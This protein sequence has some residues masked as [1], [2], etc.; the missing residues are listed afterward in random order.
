MPRYQTQTTGVLAGLNEDE[1]PHVLKDNELTKAENLARFG[2]D[3]GTRPGLVRPG[4]GE[5]YEN[6][7]SDG[8]PIQ[9]MWEYRQN[10]DE[11]RQ[12]LAV[13][14]SSGGSASAQGGGVFFEDASELDLSSNSVRVTNG[15]DHLWSFAENQNNLFA[16]GGEFTSAA[17]ADDIWHWDGTTGN[18]VDVLALTDSAGARIRPKHIIDFG[19]YLVIN[20]LRGGTIPDNNPAVSR[21][22]TFGA[23]PTSTNSWPNGNTI[24]FNA[25][26]LAGV[27]D[28]GKL[29]TTGFARYE[30]N[31][32]KFLLVLGN[33]AIAAVKL[34]I[35]N[36][37][38]VT[39]GIP[40]GCVHE[41]AFVSLGLDAG[42]AVFMS[43]RGVH[44]LR[45]SQQH[46]VKEDKFIS[47]KIRKTFA[48]LNQSRLQFSV[49][50]YDFLRGRVVFAVS[51]GSDTK[52]DFL[53]CL[54]VK[55]QN[56]ITAK[57]AIWTTWRLVGTPSGFSEKLT[58]NDLI[59]ARDST[60][61]YHLYAGT[62]TGDVIRFSEETFSD[63][64]T[65]Y[66]VEL[67]TK[68]RDYGST[69]VDKKS[70]DYYVTLSPGGNYEI[71]SKV[72]FDFGARSTKQRPVDMNVSLGAVV[73]TGVVG[74]SQ[75][76]QSD[77]T[78]IKKVYGAG[79]GATVAYN[80]S[81][82]GNNQ[83]FRV[84]KID[85][86]ILVVGEEQGEAAA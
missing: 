24:G 49:G 65:A 8:G 23:D 16:V 28:F 76:G 4:S 82:S 73:G 58:I 63:L 12:L 53:L 46:G 36:D 7:L 37:F 30:D 52:H 34:N 2:R 50:A 62:N 54:D 69:G 26:A 85:H 68:H 42:D 61:D 41:R 60:G 33:R 72:V 29:H 1:N 70:G 6:A 10:F 57:D 71:Q 45:Q 32:G 81:H 11:G 48:T 13:S 15:Q 86:D 14:E 79:S 44:S 40:N 35:N 47:W 74:V 80:V 39:D 59:F 25:A 5:D 27:T 66:P 19:G 22:T 64:D 77:R 31:E 78:F 9:G 38:Q 67:Q 20:G 21:Y 83:P 84:S 56:T 17:S 55:D 75:I 3:M 51:R 43:D 18:A